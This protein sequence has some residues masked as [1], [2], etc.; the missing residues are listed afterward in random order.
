MQLQLYP[1]VPSSHVPLLWHGLLA[2]S[3]MSVRTWEIQ[4][5]NPVSIPSR[6]SKY[7]FFVKSNVVFIA[8]NSMYINKT[9]ISMK[10]LVRLLSQ[11]YG[12]T[13]VVMATHGLH[14][15]WQSL[16]PCQRHPSEP[17]EKI[18]GT[19]DYVIDQINLAKFGFGK[20]FWDGGTYTQHIRVRLFFLFSLFL[21]I[22]STFYALDEGAAKTAELILTRNMSNDVVWRESESFLEMKNIGHWDEEIHLFEMSHWDSLRFISSLRWRM[23]VNDLDLEKV[24]FRHFVLP[25]KLWR[26]LSRE[27]YEIERWC[28]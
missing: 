27:R 13:T 24:K 21:F 22:F 18:F 17:I 2:H 10:N 11:L 23:S 19:I 6:A 7:T 5:K 9:C 3:L 14:W 26:A 4:I 16:T 8:Q 15:K 20:I 12:S 25:A 28:P 1:F